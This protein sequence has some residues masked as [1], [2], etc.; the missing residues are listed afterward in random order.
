[1]KFQT[2]MFFFLGLM[3]AYKIP[4]S[5]PPKHHPRLHCMSQ[6]RIGTALVHRCT[7]GHSHGHAQ[8]A[9]RSNFPPR[10]TGPRPAKNFIALVW[11]VA[12]LG[13]AAAGLAMSEASPGDWLLTS[14]LT[15]SL[16]LPRPQAADDTCTR[17]SPAARPPRTPVDGP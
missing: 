5:S 17:P 8:K 7:P 2:P 6:P 4:Q 13:K 3:S 16:R 14:T 9:E 12:S 10:A 15:G 11:I 1:M